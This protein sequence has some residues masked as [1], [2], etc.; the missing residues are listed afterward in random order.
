MLFIKWGVVPES[1]TP[2]SPKNNIPIN[3]I[4]FRKIRLIGG[5]QL[6]NSSLELKFHW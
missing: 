1:L 2:G 3:Q 4:W 6:T 5:F